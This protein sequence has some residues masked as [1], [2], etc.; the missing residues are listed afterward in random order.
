MGFPTPPCI[1]SCAQYFAEK[2]SAYSAKWFPCSSLLPFPRTLP[3]GTI[4]RGRTRRWD[5]D[6]SLIAC[7]PTVLIWYFVDL[8]QNGQTVSES[9]G[10]TFRMGQPSIC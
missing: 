1:P 8:L 9:T 10:R 2:S 5:S 3:S 7:S 4:G 6:N